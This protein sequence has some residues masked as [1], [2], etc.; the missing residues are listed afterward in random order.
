MENKNL[1]AILGCAKTDTQ[2]KIKKS[3][4]GK[5][6]YPNKFTQEL[7]QKQNEMWEAYHILCDYRDM[8]DEYGYE[9]VKNYIKEKN[10]K[11]EKEENK[12]N[13]QLWNL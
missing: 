10:L 8:Y 13:Y 6:Y 5:I 2:T 3:I 4:T 1:Y 11:D 7:Q 9:Y 12:K